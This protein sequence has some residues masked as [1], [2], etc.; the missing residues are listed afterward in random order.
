MES[1]T[2]EWSILVLLVRVPPRFS[3]SQDRISI[4]FCDGGLAHAGLTRSLAR[5]HKSPSAQKRVLCELPPLL[6]KAGKEEGS[7]RLRKVNFFRR[8]SLISFACLLRAPTS[9]SSLT[10]SGYSS[11]TL[12]PSAIAGLLENL[13]NVAT[14]ISHS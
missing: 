14:F 1:Q 8:S 6:L 12:P 13:L 2:R 9:P 5:I 10:Y 4:Y 11:T 3:P 7:F